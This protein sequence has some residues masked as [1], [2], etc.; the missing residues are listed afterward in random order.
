[1]CLTTLE[2]MFY[3]SLQSEMHISFFR[4]GSPQEFS[5]SLTVKMSRMGGCFY[6]WVVCTFTDSLLSGLSGRQNQ[7]LADLSR[8]ALGVVHAVS[9]KGVDRRA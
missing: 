7:K 4:G 2:S 3:G 1:M 6:F 9:R 5:N 8:T